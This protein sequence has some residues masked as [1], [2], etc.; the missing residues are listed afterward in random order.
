MIINTS[1]KCF[2]LAHATV[3][4]AVVW[5]EKHGCDSVV[6]A[7]DGLLVCGRSILPDL[8]LCLLHEPDS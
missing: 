4:S 2:I 3:N 7:D 5:I 8:S 1:L 6:I